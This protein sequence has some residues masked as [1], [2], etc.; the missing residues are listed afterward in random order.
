MAMDWEV[1]RYRLVMSM[2]HDPLVMSMTRPTL[3][4]TPATKPVTRA[5]K[6]FSLRPLLTR[7]H[8]LYQMQAPS[9]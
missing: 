2:T 3:L 7:V 5:S 6:P 8:P 9:R 4:V 1:D